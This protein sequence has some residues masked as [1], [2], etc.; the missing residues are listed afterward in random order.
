[1]LPDSCGCNASKHE[2]RET[3]ADER[4]RGVVG[5]YIL[6]THECDDVR[7]DMWEYRERGIIYYTK[8]TNTQQPHTGRLKE[9]MGYDI[10]AITIS[11]GTTN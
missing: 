10:V 8:S 3:G 9:R 7:C 1:M 2:G 5:K 6:M 11:V 4:E